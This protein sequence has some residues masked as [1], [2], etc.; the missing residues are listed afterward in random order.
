VR[1]PNLPLLRRI[2]TWVFLTV[3]VAAVVAWAIWGRD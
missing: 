2:G 3:M 1:P